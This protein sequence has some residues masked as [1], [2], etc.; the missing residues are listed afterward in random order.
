MSPRQYIT[1][2]ILTTLLVSGG[3]LLT[4]VAVGKPQQDVR[5]TNPLRG[6]PER[7]DRL[8]MFDT[9]EKFGDGRL[10][11]VRLDRIGRIVLDDRRT[12]T[13]PRYGYWTSPE[14]PTPFGFTELIPSWNA[15]VPP[16]TGVRFQARVRDARTGRW[17]PWLYFGQWGRTVA[18]RRQDQPVLTFDRGIVNVD[19]LVLDRPANAYQLRACLQSFEFDANIVPSLRRFSVTYS[20]R[21]PD[22]R[23]REQLL[24]PVKPV[25]TW[26]RDLAIPFRAQGDTAP[27]LRGQSCSPTSTTMV[28]AYF[29]VDRPTN[30]NALVIYDGEHDIFG[31]WNRAVQRAAELG[32]DGW[33]TRF[34]DWD[35]VKA[36]IAAGQPVIASINFQSRDEFPSALVGPTAGH[37]IV[38]RGFTPTGD[39]IVNDP[40]SRE[41]GNGAIYKAD[42]LA[43]AWFTNAGGVAYII[44]PPASGRLPTPGNSPVS[45]Q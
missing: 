25:G 1:L 21:V 18:A 23:L 39:A 2:A 37:L 20:G 11:H 44:R 14:V 28:M 16:G 7:V 38:I 4:I 42:E 27:P 43:R 32:L 41:K 30:E 22:R 35:Q 15:M 10:E 24:E 19:N 3:L 13:F 34:R 36:M 6:Q 26:A 17:S 8:A 12:N 29:G 31:N 40:A 9:A 33:V 45:S 5:S